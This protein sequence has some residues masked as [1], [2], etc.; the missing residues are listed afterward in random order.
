MRRGGGVMPG[1]GGGDEEGLRSRRRGT[2][3]VG[4][5]TKGW[6]MRRAW[7]P[8]AQDNTKTIM[9]MRMMSMPCYIAVKPMNGQHIQ[10]GR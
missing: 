2:F 1:V 5:H 8:W 4:C 7:E 10:A 9:T 6:R 3:R